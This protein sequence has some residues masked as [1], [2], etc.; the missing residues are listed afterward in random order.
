MEIFRFMDDFP[1]IVPK[2]LLLVSGASSFQGIKEVLEMYRDRINRVDEIEVTLERCELTLADFQ[3]LISFA[4]LRKVH[5]SGMSLKMVRRGLIHNTALMEHPKLNEIVFLG[6]EI[7]DWSG[8]QLPSVLNSLDLSWNNST[9]IS[10]LI[11]PTNVNDVY[12]NKSNIHNLEI[13]SNKI[14]S[15]LTTLMLTI[16]SITGNTWPVDL[17]ILLLNDNKLDDRALKLINDFIGWPARLTNLGISNN[18]LTKIE[19]LSNL[20]RWL[21]ILNISMNPLVCDDN[22]QTPFEFPHGLTNLNMTE[23]KTS[24][25]HFLQFPTSLKNLTLAG[26]RIVDI[27]SYGHWQ[28]LV[29]LDTLELF[30][31]LIDHLDGWII[32]PNLT[33][34]DLQVNPITELNSKFPL[35]NDNYQFKLSD[36]NLAR[37]RI[38]K[39]EVDHIPAS[40]KRLN[41]SMNRLNSKFEFPPSF[42]QLSHLDLSE[43]EIT[44][45]VFKNGEQSQLQSLDLGKNSILRGV[46]SSGLG[47]VGINQFY[48]DLELHLGK[49]KKRKFNINSLHVFER[50]RL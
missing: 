16:K 21:E 4:N 40:L 3:F 22:Q 34:L 13:L 47:I 19:N 2:R 36:L 39:I 41:L 33:K 8:I 50:G 6:H 37:C 46:A 35:F 1:E 25:L 32:P 17:D 26:N 29:N 28:K 48:D 14:P 10:T 43:N 24:D 11:I 20:P 30:H 27:S 12:F 44:S 31:N 18:E 9:D 38:T 42:K 45:I 5:F 49:V 15:N 7:N 23:C